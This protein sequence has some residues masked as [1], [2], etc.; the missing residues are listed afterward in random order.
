MVKCKVYF[1]QR[2]I[3]GAGWSVYVHPTGLPDGENG[4]LA[5]IQRFLDDV[6]SQGAEA[7]FSDAVDLCTRFGMFSGPQMPD[8]FPKALEELQAAPRGPYSYLITCDGHPTVKAVKIGFLNR[9][10][11]Q[12]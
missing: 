10:R 11:G 9:L 12:W 2:G 3:P 6:R 7:A 1:T 4:V 8:D 5:H